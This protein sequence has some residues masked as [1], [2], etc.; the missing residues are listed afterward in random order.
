MR[1]TGGYLLDKSWPASLHAARYPID[2]RPIVVHVSRVQASFTCAERSPILRPAPDT[3]SLSFPPAPLF[4]PLP[5]EE[6]CE[7]SWILYVFI[8]WGEKILS[9]S[10]FE[11]S[12]LFR[13][14]CIRS[15]R[16]VRERERGNG[17]VVTVD[18][19]TAAFNV[20]IPPMAHACTWYPESSSCTCRCCTSCA[21]THRTNS[22]PF[23]MATHVPTRKISG[24]LWG[25]ND[26][27]ATP[28]YK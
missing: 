8:I 21:I 13:F 19:L 9:L 11:E 16:T 12:A 23:P 18:P 25:W 15:R 24:H 28:A 22:W 10:L 17:D 7:N 5:K 1:A 14:I 26:T 2:V 27:P 20:L 4:F 3:R 6:D